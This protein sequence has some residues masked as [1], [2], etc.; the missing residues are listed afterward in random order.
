M[1]G[2]RVPFARKSHIEVLC[3]LLALELARLFPVLVPRLESLI[4]L[5]EGR[6]AALEVF[7]LLFELARRHLGELLQLVEV[8]PAV[9]CLLLPHALLC[10]VPLGL[11][12]LDRALLRVGHALAEPGQLLWDEVDEL[13]LQLVYGGQVLLPG[14]GTRVPRFHQPAAVR[15]GPSQ[16]ARNRIL[17]LLLQ[18]VRGVDRFELRLELRS[19]GGIGGDI[20]LFDL[21]RR[22]RCRVLRGATLHARVTVAHIRAELLDLLLVHVVPSGGRESLQLG[23]HF[24]VAFRRRLKLLALGE[25]HAAKLGRRAPL[26]LG[27]ELGAVELLGGNI[28]LHLLLVDQQPRV[29]REDAAPAAVGW[30]APAEVAARSFALE[31]L[32]VGVG[33]VAHDLAVAPRLGL[34]LVER[35]LCDV[36]RREDVGRLGV[37]VDHGVE[38][39]VV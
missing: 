14:V 37:A 10:L 20:R 6:L 21:A 12:L 32:C 35:L 29:P 23:A 38:G 17:L 3:S 18:L 19:A 2:A 8:A 36:L 5:D 15:R 39:G 22:D 4:E 13:P 24:A 34:P 9:L 26:L 31:L 11:E 28:E 7:F 25:L 16:R 30:L 1:K 27:R 33:A